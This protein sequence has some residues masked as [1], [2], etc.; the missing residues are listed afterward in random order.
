MCV[1]THGDTLRVLDSG[2]SQERQ[3]EQIS[4]MLNMGVNGIFI[5]PV[6]KKGLENVLK[7]CREKNVKVI[8]VDSMIENAELADGI[9][10]S[11]NYDAGSKLAGFLMSQKSHADILIVGRDNSGAGDDR[12][13][14]FEKKISGH[15]DY[16]VVSL[17]MTNGKSDEAMESVEK[18]INAGV[19]FDT[20]FAV[21][22]PCGIGAY[23][24]LK[25][26]NMSTIV[27]ILSVDGS[28]EGK[29]MV[30]DN[31][32]MGTAAQF[33][34]VIGSKAVEKMYGSSNENRQI[35]VPVKLITK[36][37]VDSYDKD[38]WE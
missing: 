9:V 31:K 18:M 24:A 21:N 28:P 19:K 13:I 2:M 15:A 30:K 8:I 4:R 26:H 34:T 33:T 22:D 10:L 17:E 14:G 6:E 29:H 35:L 7:Q 16:K 20:V 5:C 36:Y 27:S 11:D 23:A 25:R 37:T 38:K 32:F 1:E 12:I 3:N